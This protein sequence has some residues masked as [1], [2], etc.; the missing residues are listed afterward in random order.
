M[1]R[2]RQVIAAD[3]T[4]YENQR[5]TSRLHFAVQPNPSFE[6]RPNIKTLAPQS[7]AG[8]HPLCGARVLLLA[9]A[10][11]QTLGCTPHMSPRAVLEADILLLFG[12][13][14][15]AYFPAVAHDNPAVWLSQ[16]FDAVRKS[17]ASGD[18]IAVSLACELIAKDPMLPFGK[19]IKSDLARALK[20]RTELLVASEQAQILAA[21]LKL[22]NQE[23]APRE[24]E[25][26]CKL[27]KK[28]AGSEY[29]APLLLAVPKNPKSKKLLAY[30]AHSAA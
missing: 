6:A 12:T 18:K 15:R 19:L 20:K 28:L 29:W 11:I 21:T 3:A 23:Y 5:A 26:Y 30:L 14:L 25:D 13:R 10:S 22:L 8:Y 9:S 1:L 2:W 7:G 4:R 16:T 17:I 24:L 27:A